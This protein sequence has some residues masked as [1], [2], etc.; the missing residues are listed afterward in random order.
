MFHYNEKFVSKYTEVSLNF[1]FKFLWRFFLVNF[2]ISLFPLFGISYIMF[3]FMTGLNNVFYLLIF[4][5]TLLTSF[6]ATFITFKL[7]SKS[8][9][10][11]RK[12]GILTR[13]TFVSK[14]VVG[15]SENALILNVSFAYFW[16]VCLVAIGL[17]ILI[18]ILINLLNINLSNIPLS[19][20]TSLCSL[21]LGWYWFVLFN[22]R[23][24]FFIKFIQTPIN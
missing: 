16:R 5:L 21:F 8:T 22:D 12:T 17:N 23:E 15:L 14:K 2:F 11:E 6:V 4:L 13:I 20:I 1:F 18:F 10:T 3:E 7:I 24:G 9:V 19:G